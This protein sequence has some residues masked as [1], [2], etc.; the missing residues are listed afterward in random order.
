MNLIVLDNFLPY[1]NIVRHW[2]LKQEFFDCEQMTKKVGKPNTWPGLRTIGI[3]ELD[4]G[5][6]NDVLSKMSYLAQ[7]HFGVPRNIHIR[8]AFQLTRKDDGNSWIHR[9]DDVDVAC[10]LYLTPN[11]PFSSGTNLYSEPP[12]EVTDN[13]G[14]VYNRLVMYRAN[15]Y[16]KSNEYFG[17]NL[18]NGRLTL[19]SFIKVENE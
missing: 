14:N 17:D 11:A 10:L 19:V 1:P 8:S 6:A 15:I 2:A 12:H 18:E 5:F 13:I 16:H 4:I 3:N 9:D 7:Y